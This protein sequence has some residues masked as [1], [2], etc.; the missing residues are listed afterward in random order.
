MENHPK[1]ELAELAATFSKIGEQL[2]QDY[3]KSATASFKN[4]GLKDLFETYSEFST[5][6][7]ENPADNAKVQDLFK[8]FVSNQQELWKRILERQLGLSKNYEP[9][10]KPAE[11]D[12]RFKSPEWDQ[13]P[14]YFDFVKQSYLLV[15]KLLHEVVDAVELPTSSK[16]KLSFY[17]KQYLDAL[18]P[19]N[20]AATNPEVLKL[21]QETN[22]ASIIEGFK[23]FLTDFEKGSITQ[24]DMT[25]FTPGHNIAITPGAVVYENELIQLIQYKPTTEQVYEKPLLVIPP[26]INKYYILDLRPENSF[27]KYLVDQ[28]INTFIISYKNPTTE[29][30]AADITW[31]DYVSKAAMKAIEVIQSITG[32]KKINTIG[33]CIGGTLLSTTLAIQAKTLSKAENPI[34]TATFLATMVDFSDVGPMGDIIDEKLVKSLEEGDTIKNGILSGH[35][36]EYAFNFIRANDLVWSFVINSYL[37]GKAPAPFDIMYWTNDNTNLPAKMY[38]FYLRQM[39]FENKLSRKNALRILDTQ[40]DIGKIEVPTTVIGFVEDHIAPAV[41]TFT[42][43]ELVSG[44]VEYILGESGHVMGVVNHPSKKKYGYY[45]DGELEHGFQHWKDTAK[46][47]KESWWTIWVEVIEPAPGRYVIE[48]NYGHHAPKAHKAHKAEVIKSEKAK[49]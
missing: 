34:N 27:T 20:F 15:S 11:N 47:T 39:V 21:A 40:V 28:G 25:A 46:Y 36:M 19:S 13:A 6:L 3:I 30:G 24:T 48:K 2:T 7:L 17:T 26:W 42:T 33:Y 35:D 10:I 49:K 1:N 12:K 37:K 23:N 16:K 44:P 4:D 22:G 38:L 18:A 45:A 5:R 32:A 8:N 14:Y 9:V 29:G 43:T 41:T 31:D